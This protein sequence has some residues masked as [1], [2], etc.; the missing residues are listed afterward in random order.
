MANFQ[1]PERVGIFF[2]FSTTQ[3]KTLPAERRTPSTKH[4]TPPCRCEMFARTVSPQ[5]KMSSVIGA[6]QTAALRGSV[7]LAS[8]RGQQG[9]VSTFPAGLS[10]TVGEKGFCLG[11]NTYVLQLRKQGRLSEDRQQRNTAAL[12]AAS[13]RG[14]DADQLG[15]QREGVG[16]G[17]RGAWGRRRVGCFGAEFVN[18]PN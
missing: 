16:D 3:T 4:N 12:C 14:P 7:A 6:T 15:D 13:T 11:V 17:L 18:T 9:L 2:F 5:W 1:N 10:L 8:H